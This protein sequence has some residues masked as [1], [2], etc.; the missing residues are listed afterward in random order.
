VQI[1][2][3]TKNR[4]KILEITGFFGGLDNKEGVSGKITWKNF[5]DFKDF[6]DVREGTESFL[7]NAIKKAR[8]IAGYTGIITLADDSGLEV[9]A[10]GGEPGV[11]SSVYAGPC[12]SDEENRKKLLGR[13]KDINDMD[14]RIAR[15]ICK[16]V[17]WDPARGLLNTSDGVCEGRI[18]FAEMG[19]GGFG[20]DPIFIPAGYKKTMAQLSQQEKN[21]ISHR[22]KALKKMMVF[23][24][25]QLH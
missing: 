14:R 6:P 23:F 3:A 10:L 25:T 20:Y 13:L 18:G 12:A 9:D 2:I 16:M 21:M 17:L 1:V 4:G 7:E 11:I 22:G 19:E 8:Q 5:Q 15:F 24:E